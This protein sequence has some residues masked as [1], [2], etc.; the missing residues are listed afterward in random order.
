M[1][2]TNQLWSEIEDIY[3]AILDHPFIDE[4]AEGSLD[5]QIFLF[6]MKQDAH[7]L[8]DFS[9][10]LAIAG[11]KSADNDTFK[12]FLDFSKEAIVVERALHETFFQDYEVKL[13]VEKSPSC[14][15]YTNFLMKTAY[16]SPFPQI[17]GG[18]L[19][20]FWIYQ[21]VGNYIV[22]KASSPNPYQK[23]IDTYSGEEF[24]E[25]VKKALEI[26]D[27]IAEKQ[28]DDVLSDITD[29]FVYAARLEW[30][31]WDSAYRM[32]QW[33]PVTE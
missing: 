16:H 26:V 33:Q 11:A 7:Y 4:L 27:D 15:S 8:A 6:Y 23:W 18:L 31:F 20:C 29:K 9:R 17:A 14:F 32:E 2:F 22:E 10:A 12:T 1:R 3:S 25:G 5:E 24:Q 30:M 21:E 28:P 13:N 19:P